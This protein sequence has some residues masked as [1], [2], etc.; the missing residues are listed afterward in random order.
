TT[1]SG[2]PVNFNVIFGPATSSN[3]FITLLGGGTVTVV[4]WQPGNS[5]YNAAATVQ[6]SFAVSKI[7]QTISFGGLSPQKAGDA[8]FSLTA[9]ASS[10]LPV[11]VAVVS[12][13]AILNGNILTLTG[14]GTVTISASQPGD[15]SYAPAANV[16][17]SFF[18]SPPDNTIA[19]PQ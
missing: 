3:N 12:G 17:Q 4:A 7:P 2:L 1:S 15:N 19:N 16:T 10:G 6:Q 18:V 11:G 9:T 8:P 13:P 14:W 5:N